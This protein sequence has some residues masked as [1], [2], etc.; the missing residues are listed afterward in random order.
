MNAEKGGSILR[1]GL[2]KGSLEKSTFELMDHAGFEVSL[3]SRSYYPT[4]A[5]PEMQGVMFRAQ[6][7]SRYVENGVVDVGLTGHDWILENG[8]DVVEV[9]ELIYSKQRRKPARWV[10]AVPAESPVRKVEDLDGK[11]IAT[12][13]VGVTRKFFEQRGVN[14]KVEFS[15]GATEVKARLVDA[16]VEVTETGSSLKANNLRILDEVLVSTTRLIASK[17]AWQDPWKRRKIE[18]LALLL[19]GAIVARDMVGLKLNVA[20]P[21][22][23]KV[24]GLL[25]AMKNPTVAPLAG[26]HWFA[27]D[28][29]IDESEVRSLIPKLKEAGGQGIIEYPLNK[30]IP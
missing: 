6:E 15:W 17:Q 3:G 5:D 16:I 29:I 1:V 10:I 11:I 26:N 20:E 8:S 7:M 21:D 4:I 27:V 18:S 9:A 14:A 30:V 19:Q 12:E 23:K 28:T 22:L 25:P 13:L 24:L 2:P